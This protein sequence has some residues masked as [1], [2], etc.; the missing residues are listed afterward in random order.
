MKLFHTSPTKI[1]RIHSLG[2]FGECLCF[3]ARPY[4]MPVVENPVVYAI[5][6]DE[7]QVIECRRFFFHEDAAKLQPLVSSVM[8]MVGCDEDTAEDLLD[9][10]QALL[11]VAATPNADQDYEIQR[12][13]GLAAKLLGYRA[14]M[15]FAEQGSL[16]LVNMAGHEAEL[17]EQHS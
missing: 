14:A 17:E 9:G 3:A 8:R 5:E 16:W 11:D 4:F 15:T 2:L 1:E 6:I 12:L 10:R 7:A 13:Q